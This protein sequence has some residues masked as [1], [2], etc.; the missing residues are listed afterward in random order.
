MRI[1]T[2]LRRLPHLV[3]QTAERLWFERRAGNAGV[4]FHLCY[5]TCASY[6]R[7]LYCSLHSL[8]E[9]GNA[10]PVSVIIF[11]QETDPFSEE[12]LQAIARV[13]PDAR[14]LN[15]PKAQGWGPQEIGEIWRAYALV[16][17]AAAEGDYIARIDSDVFF[18]S[19]W[20]LPLV[21]RSGR[22]FVG[23]GHFVAFKYAQGGCYFAR[24]SAVRRVLGLLSGSPVHQVLPP[25]DTVVEDIAAYR[26][27]R[28]VG[29][30][31]WLIWIMMFPDEW[32]KA[33][34]L[35]RRHRWKFACL[36]FT[37][38]DKGGMLSAYEEQ[39]L[40]PED[41]AAY[42][43]ALAVGDKAPVPPVAAG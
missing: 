19:D 20:L 5:F 43:A 11:C 12:Q 18:F 13:A 14:L 24:V 32:R 40:R 26:L 2:K 3:R 30:R 15:W 39:V 37:A 29:A 16:A 23:D 41:R 21:A 10:C 38:K 27:M 36:H 22:E 34:R 35:G 9:L 33:G 8:R 31:I 25:E 4:T 7:Y 6:Y 42:H 28:K 17:E 1:P